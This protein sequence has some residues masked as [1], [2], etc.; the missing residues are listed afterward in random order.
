M[1][2]NIIAL[3][4]LVMCLSAG[5]R[6]NAMDEWVSPWKSEY[7]QLQVYNECMRPFD[8]LDENTRLQ[9]KLDRKFQEDWSDNDSLREQLDEAFRTETEEIA[10]E[11]EGMG[12]QCYKL[13]EW[14]KRYLSFK[15]G[16]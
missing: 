14:K 16:A 4:L 5:S 1:K 7:D 6:L 12:K 15:F 8:K 3:S 2:K 9:E 11:I 13:R 10:E